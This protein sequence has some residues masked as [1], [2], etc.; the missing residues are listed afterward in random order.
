[1]PIKSYI[2]IP[3]LDQKQSL[4]DDIAKMEGCEVHPAE[5]KEVLVLV[6]D[7]ETESEDKLLISQI[8]SNKN[9]KHISLVS[10]YE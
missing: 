3:Q 10:G 4:M 2:I 1:M 8:E 5:N 9:I 7:V 6:T